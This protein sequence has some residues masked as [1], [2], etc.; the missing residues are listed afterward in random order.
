MNLIEVVIALLIVGVLLYVVNK[1]I[2]MDQSIKTILHIVVV[3]VVVLW[4]LQVFGV[5]ALPILTQPIAR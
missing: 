5:L 2:P 4:L 3:I 1:Y